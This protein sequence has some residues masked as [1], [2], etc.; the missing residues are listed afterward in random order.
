MVI[1]RGEKPVLASVLLPLAVDFDRKHQLRCVALCYAVNSSLW[2]WSTRLCSLSHL[3]CA[4][5]ERTV[6]SASK[7]HAAAAQHSR[8]QQRSIVD[9]PTPPRILD[10]VRDG[11]VAR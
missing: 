10:H 4:S 9:M 1:V 11:D 5:H 6:C 8:A 7:R 2:Y 3:S